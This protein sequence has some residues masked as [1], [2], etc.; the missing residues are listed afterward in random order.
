MASS[1]VQHPKVAVIGAG[2]L[3]FGRQAIWQMVH[4]P[5]LNTG[6]LALV[7]T[8]GKRL[9]KMAALA[10]MVIAEAG[11]PL[12]L[13]ASTERMDVLADC[14]FVVLTF[15]DRSVMF[16][17][18]DCEVSEKYGVR[19]CS[20]DTTGPGGIFRTMRE[21]PVILECAKD[22][23]AL[24]PDAWVVSYINPTAVHG[25]GLR[26]YAP[27]LKSFALCDGLHMPHVKR[28]YAQRAGIIE[29]EEDYSD[30]IAA[31]FDMRIAGVNHFTWMLKAEYE[32][33]DVLPAIAEWLRK[34][35]ATETDGGDTGAK[36]IYNETIGYALYEAFGYI[37]TCVGHT[38]EYVRFWQ[39]LGKSPETVP[40]LSIWETEARY[41][42]HDE[43]WRQVD[44]FLSGDTPISEYM[45]TFGPDHATD[46]IENMVGGL[47]KPFHV[48]T[49]NQG[50]VANMADDA[51]LELLCDVDM[52]G[53]RPRPVGDMPPGLHGMQRLVLDAHELTADAVARRDPRLLRRAMLTDPLT[54]SIGDADAIIRDLIEAE[55]EVL[56]DCWL[57]LCR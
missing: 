44:G 21:F 13:E 56:D 47:G 19:M 43:M 32:G 9:E 46:I 16:R 7:D 33:R 53:P 30:E 55:K 3:F 54:N 2:S 6:T 22:I 50:A 31:E 27:Q 45:T 8:D 20:G 1:R 37:P 41:K 52:E 39:G 36:A 38:K 15:A 29:R 10:R 28:Y 57:E 49:A 34:Q 48:N 25:L 14:D 40:P 12:E 51:F 23:E 42:I 5:H 11:V 17:G 18:I 4:S 35:A 24:C 26:K